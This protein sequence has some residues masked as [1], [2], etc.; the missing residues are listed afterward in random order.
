MLGQL[1]FYVFEDTLALLDV[2]EKEPS[3]EK[4]SCTIDQ[5][6]EMGHNHPQM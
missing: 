4:H 1:W 6:L 3:G 5:Q 2:A